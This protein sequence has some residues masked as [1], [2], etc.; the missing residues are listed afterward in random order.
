M[1]DRVRAAVVAASLLALA[2]LQIPLHTAGYRVSGDDVEALGYALEG[3]GA[4]WA[5]T[6]DVLEV[7]GRLGALTIQP[8]TAVGAVLSANL[9][10]RIAIAA[11]YLAVAAL[12]AVW[13]A[14]HWSAAA[15]GMLFLLLTVLQPLGLPHLPP[16]SYP[17]VNT[18]PFAAILLALLLL[19][20]TST[21]ATRVAIGAL[22]A[23]ALAANEY[24]LL[25]GAALI[26]GGWLA[27]IL[28]AEDAWP[29]RLRALAG[30]PATRMEAAS[31]TLAALAVIGWRLTH[32]S[33][34]GGVSADGAGRPLAM[35]ETALRHAAAGIGWPAVSGGAAAW[36]PSDLAMMAAA[37]LL[38]AA[39]TLL[40]L[41]RLALPRAAG[42]A[43]A[44]YAIAAVLLVTLPVAAALRQQ[45]WCLEGGH[46]AYLDSRSAAPFLCLL[47]VLAL[48]A[49]PKAKAVHWIAAVAMGCAAAF[50]MQANLQLAR[51]MDEMARPWQRAADLACA[52]DLWP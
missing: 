15:G 51:A 11:G 32:P 3:P 47:L 19:D 45:R 13:V 36:G 23:M 9:V 38:T 44:F 39:A 41:P 7:Q 24:A 40:L 12:V 48:T 14:R 43:T 25:F 34:Y 31:L 21:T 26:G 42:L 4:V 16:A 49:L 28:R 2:A 22:L 37:A 33:D 35:L 27:R 5:W 10:G 6:L 17:L 52:P 8:L 1:S 30:G 18:V 50:V 29:A 20:R 46:C